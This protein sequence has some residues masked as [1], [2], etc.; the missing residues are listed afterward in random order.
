MPTVIHSRSNIAP[1]AAHVRLLP[2]PPDVERRTGDYDLEVLRDRGRLPGSDGLARLILSHPDD[3]ACMA[4]ATKDGWAAMM[5]S[6]HATDEA[7]PAC[8]Q[9]C[10][11]EPFARQK[12]RLI[13][14]GDVPDM[15]K[16]I[17]MVWQIGWGCDGGCDGALTLLALGRATA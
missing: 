3:P 11:E 17:D 5:L 14:F 10:G 8:A 2:I 4:L 6:R 13:E 9:R 1:P 16:A 15:P 12:L 7:L